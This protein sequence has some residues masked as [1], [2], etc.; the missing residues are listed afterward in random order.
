MLLCSHFP[1]PEKPSKNSLSLWDSPQHHQH[2]CPVFILPT[3]SLP[4]WKTYQWLSGLQLS[5]M[6]YINHS[7]HSTISKC[8][9]DNLGCSFFL[10]NGSICW[11]L[12]TWQNS[13]WT[14]LRFPLTRYN[15]LVHSILHVIIFLPEALCI[16]IYSI[17][18][19]Q[20]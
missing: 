12:R 20:C 7:V 2:N 5:K 13:F 10:S 14:C 15:N 6:G 8:S 17:S 4:F 1:L 9:W 16:G 18:N 19:K 3:P 11:S